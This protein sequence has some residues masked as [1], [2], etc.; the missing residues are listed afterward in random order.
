MRDLKCFKAYD[1][2]GDFP[3]EIDAGLAFALGAGIA[4][5]LGAANICLGHD[6]RQ[7]GRALCQALAA[8]LKASGAKAHSLGLCCTEE[9]YHAAA[10]H[11]F[12]AGV[13]VT[14]SH[15]P[16]GQNGFKI[17][18]AGAIPVSA[19]SGLFELRDYVAQKLERD[20]QQAQGEAEA[21]NYRDEYA[22]WLLEY[23]GLKRPAGLRRLKIAADAGNGCA[24]LLLEKLA[25]KL[26]FDFVVVRGEPDG[27]FP[28]GIPNPLLPENR[29][30][31]AQAVREHKADLGIAWDGD[32]D[33]CFFYDETGAFV[34]G[35]YLVGLLAA[36]MLE[37]F[38]GSRV[39]HDTRVYWNTREMVLAAGG[40]P[41]M[42][43]TGHAFMKEKMRSENAIYGGE[44]SAHHYFRDFA[45]C[46]SGMLPWL[47]AASMLASSDR[48][49][50]ALVAGRMAAWP[51]S[52]EIN[53]S[54]ERPRE[55]MDLIEKKY[56][57][58]AMRH[59]RVDGVNIE[60]PDWRFNLRMSNTE[61]L[62]RL[63]VESRGNHDLMLEKTEELLAIIDSAK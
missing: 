37:L 24:G 63:N 9:I 17:V 62:L 45:F 49:M 14:G 23:S 60:F 31:A 18:R 30:I 29:G 1:I 28:T 4:E 44:M 39:I 47:F 40:E 19:D 34:E 43:K 13:M 27:T 54:L 26:P 20:Q 22:D 33:R 35:Y 38:P 16:A 32:A 57:P 21:V 36:R 50:S 7:S 46:D 58:N 11:P 5:K 8:G 61:P 59:D 52:G 10:T 15:N 51:C 6:A 3:G 53:R 48:P 41:V 25:P 12:D 2:R 42:G 55:I 56:A